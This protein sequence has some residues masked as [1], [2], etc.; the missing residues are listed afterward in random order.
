LFRFDIV[1][2]FLISVLFFISISAFDPFI[3]AYASDLGIQPAII[4]SIIGAAGLTSLFTRLPVGILSDLLH[5]RKL[6]LQAG[7]LITIVTWTVAFLY[8]SATTLYI[9][10]LSDGLTSATWVI[11]NVMFAS[12]FSAREAVKAVAILSVASPV[13]S[14]VGSTIGGIIANQYGYQYSFLT[15]AAAGALAFVLLF[16][17]KEKTEPEKAVQKYKMSTFTEQLTDR[18]IWILSIVGTIAMMVLFGTRDT[19]TPIVAKE[20]GANPFIISLLAN[21]HLIFYG[22]AAALCGS[23]FYKKLGLVQTAMTG[24]LLQGIVAMIIPFASALP[25]L[26]VL[27]AF[28]GIGFGLCFTVVTSLSIEGTPEYQRSTRMGLFQSIYSGGMFFGPVIM[29]IV[30]Q[31]FSLVSGFVLMGAI[32]LLA[33]LLTK[34]LIK[35]VPIENI[36]LNAEEVILAS[37]VEKSTTS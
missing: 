31:T 19:F 16:F 4:G 2:F 30:T 11:Y 27:Q 26:F 5:R 15:A 14:L 25:L 3:S 6:F 18:K 36:I 22:A 37:Q 21:T 7:L 33:M 13:G 8:P 23:F 32:S 20:L 17:V 34:L 35:P 1:L 29:G 12:L 10:K 24:F 28:M 9:G